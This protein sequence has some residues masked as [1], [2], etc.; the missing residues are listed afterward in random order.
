MPIR[1]SGMIPTGRAPWATITHPS[2]AHKCARIPLFKPLPPILAHLPVTEQK[3]AAKGRNTSPMQP[4][5]SRMFTHHAPARTSPVRNVR[6]MFDSCTFCF[7]FF[8][9]LIIL[10]TLSVSIISIRFSSIPY[11]YFLFFPL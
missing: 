11:F 1:L 9:L 7:S 3:K 2:K 8:L 5:S 6:S 4:S 10:V